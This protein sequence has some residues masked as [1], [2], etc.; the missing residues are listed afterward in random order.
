M[1]PTL[2][3]AC[4]KP[5]RRCPQVAR[6]SYCS[7]PP[8]QRDRR[9]LWQQAA[10]RKD[11]AYNDNQAR[12]QK[13]WCER[14]PHYWSEYRRRHPEYQK[15]N[16]ALQRVRNQ[17]R[18]AQVIAK[19]TA[20][21]VARAISNPVA[22][23]NVS[24]PSLSTLSGLYRIIPISRS[25]LP[26]AASALAPMSAKMDEWIAEIRLISAVNEA[27]RPTKPRL[28]REDVMG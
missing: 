16:R 24:D 21:P 28:Q 7:A 23:M 20:N 10:R 17:R 27:P 15:R 12:A 3:T 13:E 22:K 8:C 2:C 25:V 26:E 1:E 6:Q 4:G 5:F 9:R 18:K 14:N 19:L 11:P